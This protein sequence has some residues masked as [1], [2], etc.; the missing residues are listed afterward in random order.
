MHHSG[1]MSGLNGSNQQEVGSESSGEYMSTTICSDDFY[2]DNSS[3]LCKPECGV[4]THLTPSKGRV[5]LGLRLFATSI[6][7]TS[8]LLVLA[9]SCAQYKRM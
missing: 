4:W 8:S 9:L 1:F 3:Q 5:V 2:F 6:G 7:V